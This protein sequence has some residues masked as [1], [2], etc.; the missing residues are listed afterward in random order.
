[1]SDLVKQIIKET[2]AKPKSPDE[3]RFM[4]QHTVDTK[5]YPVKQDPK[6]TPA[7]TKRKADRDAAESEKDYDQAY[8][9]E[10]MDGMVCKDCGDEF[11]KPKS[12]CEHDCHDEN[13]SNWVKQS[14]MKEETETL[15]EAVIDTLKD[16]VKKKSAKSVKFADGSSTKVDMMTASAMTQV[17]DALNS[18]N[19]KK[20]ADAINKNEQMFMKMMDFAF[21]KV[22]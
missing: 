17:H 7:K 11:G 6:S 19:Q 21:S 9:K 12:D 16:I 5:D 18:A 20:F 3:Q 14:E 22:K 4:D 10:D 13:G 1:M 8:V 2:V 15:S